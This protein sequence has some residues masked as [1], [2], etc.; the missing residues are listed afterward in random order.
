MNIKYPKLAFGIKF[1]SEGDSVEKLLIYKAIKACTEKV[2]GFVAERIG[3]VG[4]K[5]ETDLEL[6]GTTMV[7]PSFMASM[8]EIKEVEKERSLLCVGVSE[9]FDASWEAPED[10]E[11]RFSCFNSYKI[12]VYIAERDFVTILNKLR[13]YVFSVYTT[14]NKS[15]SPAPAVRYFSNFIMVGNKRVAY[16]DTATL[17]RLINGEEEKEE[18][19]ASII[20]SILSRLA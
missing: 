1:V 15:Y 9:K 7:T 14:S 17:N 18:S 4:R 2:P 3:N 19:I 8:I 13:E 6:N 11:N 10:L 20:S 5:N 16:G 12:P